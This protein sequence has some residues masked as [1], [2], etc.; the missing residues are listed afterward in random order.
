MRG[1]PEM[2]GVYVVGALAPHLPNA[3]ELGV[4]VLRQTRQQMEPH[5]DG[6]HIL[7]LQFQ[8]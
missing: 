5:S 6:R 4:Q 2:H 8:A 1:G 3:P 7:R